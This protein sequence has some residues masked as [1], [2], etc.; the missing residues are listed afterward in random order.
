MIKHNVMKL[1]QLIELDKGFQHYLDHDH[2]T[3]IAPESSGAF[4]EFVRESKSETEIPE[5]P[6]LANKDR[7]MQ[8]IS[9]KY[10]GMP[11]T[12]YWVTKH[13]GGGLQFKSLQ[14]YIEP[15]RYKLTA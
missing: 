13:F 2:F 3:L 4:E 11:L 14:E 1:A 8:I 5:E 12:I 9:Q 15:R 6:V 10:A 7:V